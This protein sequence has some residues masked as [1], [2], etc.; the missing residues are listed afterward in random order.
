MQSG[1]VVHTLN[2]AGNDK[3]TRT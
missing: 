3:S 2:K 1:G